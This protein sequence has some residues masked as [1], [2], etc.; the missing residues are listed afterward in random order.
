MSLRARVITAIALVL[1][2]GAA[3]GA[4]LAGLQARQSLRAELDAALLGGRQT[5][6]SAFEAAV[7]SS[8]PGPAPAGGDLR[9]Q[10]A[11]GGGAD[12]R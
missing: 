1:L 5:V 12:R 11:R 9:W 2:L 8:G 3:T 7:G 10:S 6:A 4:L